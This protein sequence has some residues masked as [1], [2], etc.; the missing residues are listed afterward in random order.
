MKFQQAFAMRLEAV[1]VQAAD[2]LV[3]V[4]KM[5]FDMRV[6]DVL[7]AAFAL[8]HVSDRALKDGG[9]IRRIAVALDLRMH[10]LFFLLPERRC[11][12]GGTKVGGNCPGSFIRAK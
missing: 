2:P 3:S 12:Q 4:G 6:K 9:S 5:I 1:V 8:D 11:L 7:I 10:V